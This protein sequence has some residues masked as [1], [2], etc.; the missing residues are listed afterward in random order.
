VSIQSPMDIGGLQSSE[1]LA[2]NP[3]GKMPL[4]VDEGLCVWESDAICRHLLDKHA[5]DGS[6]PSLWPSSISER[7][8]SEMICRHHDAYLGP[9]QG[10]LYKP[11]P[12]FGR[13][14]TRADA[15]RELVKQLGVVESLCHESGPYLT[16]TEPSLADCTLFPTLVFIVD[17]LQKFE[18]K[19]VAD[20]APEA[21]P[22]DAAAEAFG[23]RLLAYWSHMTNKDEEAMRVLNEI[24]GGL[25]PW[26]ARDR[27]GA[28]LGAGTRDGA[29]P[30]LF[31]KILSK[32]IPSEMVYEDDVCYAFR[33]INPVAPT[34]VLIIPKA[35][36]GLTGLGAATSEHAATLGHLMVAAAKVAKQEGLDDFRLVSNNGVS[37][38]QSV[39]HLHLHVIGGRDLTWPPG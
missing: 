7:T 23:P 1:Y 29:P 39:F 2:L 5:N 6:G 18:E 33:D 28:L 3:Q 8:T 12:P 38:C 22:R 27:W 35:R 19:I 32:E 14:G 26:E 4:L 34:H 36:D 30:T 10:C 9:I 25:E 17:M 16:G 11:A 15:I 24:R 21:M 37:A 31:D 13:F 20:V